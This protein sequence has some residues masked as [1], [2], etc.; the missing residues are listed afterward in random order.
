M[1]LAVVDDKNRPK[2]PV[3]RREMEG[4]P[5]LSMAPKVL[6]RNGAFVGI[7]RVMGFA[8]I[9]FAPFVRN[10]NVGRRTDFDDFREGTVRKAESGAA[11]VWR[12]PEREKLM[13]VCEAP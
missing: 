9:S 10:R 7:E 4:R 2:T 8:E 11:L 3:V 13:R 1:A 5:W 12:K 6:N